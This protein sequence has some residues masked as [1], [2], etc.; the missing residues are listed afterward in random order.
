MELINLKKAGSISGRNNHKMKE[1][2][3]IDRDIIKTMCA[4]ADLTGADT[5]LEI[6]AGTG[7]LTEWLVRNCKFV[8]AI[9]KN[10]EF[11][12]ILRDKFSSWN[13]VEIIHA[14]ALKIDFP[15]FNKT[16]SNLPYSISRK[17]T[18]KLL[19]EKFDLGI[20]VYQKEFAE[21]LVANAGSGMYKFIGA[22]AQSCAK[23]NVLDPIP[24]SAFEPVPNVW[25]AIVKI[26]PE[27]TAD[28]MYIKFL[29]SLFNH[30]NK[31]ITNIIDGNVPEKF[32]GMRPFDLEISDLRELYGSIYCE[33][34]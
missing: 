4:Y 10:R 23:I 18:E 11:I 27:M 17:I 24:P 1:H 14:N 34:I 7:N 15:G 32:E 5:V 2:F 25:S 29:H 20:L 16:V 19:R 12:D 21:K 9:E 3:M 26:R 28:D 30:R 31:K 22:L 33:G 13:N 6:G 8:Y